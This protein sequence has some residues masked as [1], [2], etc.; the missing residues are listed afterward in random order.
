[1]KILLADDHVLFLE[2]ISTILK[3]YEP[4]AEIDLAHTGFDVVEKVADGSYD[5]IILDLRLPGLDGF[6]LL[7]KFREDACLIPVIVL[8]ASDNPAD[9]QSAKELGARGFLSKKMTGQEIIAATRGVI[10]GELAYAEKHF[11]VEK[12]NSNSDDWAHLHDI[13]PRQLEVLRAIRQGMSNQEIARSLFITEPT[14]KSH[15]S[16]IFSALEVKSRT[17]AVEKA[18]RLGLD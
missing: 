15:I 8:T 14:V 11:G 3:S 12:V 13:S 4:S 5:V 17:E 10:A 18:Q 6:S 9:A 2:G 7:K 16:A 1:M